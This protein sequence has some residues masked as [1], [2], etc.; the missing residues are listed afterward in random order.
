MIT[1]RNTINDTRLQHGHLAQICNEGPQHNIYVNTTKE[2]T[3]CI[4]ISINWDYF[5]N[6]EWNTAIFNPIYLINHL[7]LIKDSIFWIVAVWN[8]PSIIFLSK[9]NVKMKNANKL[10]V[11]SMKTR[12]NVLSWIPNSWYNQFKNPFNGNFLYCWYNSITR[13]EQCP[14]FIPVFAHDL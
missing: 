10:K 13:I 7:F 3:F 1:I 2:R 12:F 14:P 5:Y 6:E 8:T 4:G 11:L 9:W